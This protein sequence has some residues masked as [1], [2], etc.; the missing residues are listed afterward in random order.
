MAGCG[1]GVRRPAAGKRNGPRPLHFLQTPRSAGGAA[2]RP[3]AS[4]ARRGGG[5]RSIAKGQGGKERVRGWPDAC[6]ECRGDK[7]GRVV[8]AGRGP[9]LL[10]GLS[11]GGSS[12]VLDIL[13]NLSNLSI[14]LHTMITRNN[15]CLLVFRTCYADFTGI[16]NMLNVC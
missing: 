11:A 10:R 16:Q 15:G 13:A 7:G 14:T 4:G 8:S 9:A 12:L 5:S 6:I 2:G 1:I 3:A